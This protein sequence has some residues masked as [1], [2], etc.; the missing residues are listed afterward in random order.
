MP[1]FFGDVPV[2]EIT[3]DL[4]LKVLTPIWAEKPNEADRVRARIK[5]VLD[6]AKVRGLRQGENPAEWQGHLNVLLAKPSD[7]KPPEHYP[8]LPYAEI[9]AFRLK[10]RQHQSVSALALEF[11]LLNS[12][13]PGNVLTAHRS[14]INFRDEVWEIPA[15]KMKGFKKVRYP[16]GKFRVPLSR[17]AMAI[18]YEMVENYAGDFLFPGEGLRGSLANNS[19]HELLNGLNWGHITAHGFRATFRTWANDRTVCEKEVKEMALGHSLGNR[20][21][22]AYSRSDLFEKRRQLMN[23]WAT[24]VTAPADDRKY[25]VIGMS[26]LVVPAGFNV[27][28]TAALQKAM[29]TQES[30]KPLSDDAQPRH[31]T[32]PVRRPRSPSSQ[33]LASKLSDEPKGGQTP[34]DTHLSEMHRTNLTNEEWAVVEP[35]LSVSRGKDPRRIVSGILWA[36]RTGLGYR[37]IPGAGSTWTTYYN[38]YR[39]WEKSGI[40]VRVIEALRTVA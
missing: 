12:V 6:A 21:E 10:L 19:F 2:N 7:V 27:A 30:L 23:A 40:W 34:S 13:R 1:R 39:K 20:T 14:E 25:Y 15:G 8:S 29:E 31:R 3:T 33:T 17:P 9:Q 24:F 18:V 16:G 5:A 38:S 28:E 4:V 35:L 37:K 32:I 22:E 36:Q 11:G 26:D